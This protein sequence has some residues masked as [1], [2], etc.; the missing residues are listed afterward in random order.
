MPTSSTSLFHDLRSLPGAFRVLFAGTFINRFGS[1]VFPFLT[2]FLTRRGLSSAEIGLVLT[3]FGLG[4]LAAT[5]AGGWFL[6]LHDP[7]WLFA[8]NALGT[9]AYCEVA[10]LALPRG[11]ASARPR[12]SW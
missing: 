9:V 4:A 8:G 3:G 6:V 10:L 12:P 5:L 11:G 1:F 7:L 2:I